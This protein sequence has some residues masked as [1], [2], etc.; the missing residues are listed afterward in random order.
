MAGGSPYHDEDDIV[1]QTR[2]TTRNVSGYYS[3]SISTTWQNDPKKVICNYQESKMRVGSLVY[4]NATAPMCC[5]PKAFQR[6]LLFNGKAGKFQGSQ[7]CPKGPEGDGPFAKKP[8]SLADILLLDQNMLDYPTC[9]INT[10]SS[11]D[12]YLICSQLRYIST[13]LYYLFLSLV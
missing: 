8:T 10:D 3:T 12:R 4:V 1:A 9:D 7:F 13:S 2:I 6:E 11:S 5:C